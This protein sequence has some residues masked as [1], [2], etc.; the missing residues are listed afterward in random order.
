MRGV[1]VLPGIIKSLCYRAT[2]LPVGG[3]LLQMCLQ[4]FDVHFFKLVVWVMETTFFNARFTL[5]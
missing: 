2:G 5:T 3:V 4:L 1:I